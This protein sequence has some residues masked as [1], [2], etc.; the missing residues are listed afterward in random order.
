MRED[1]VCSV[2]GHVGEFVVEGVGARDDF[3]CGQCRSMVRQRDVA[4]LVID[5]F[6]RGAVLSM[7][8]AVSRGLLDEVQIYEVG[9]QGPIHSRLKGL[10]RYVNSYFWDD[11]APGEVRNGVRCEDLTKL[12]FADESFDLIL[13][14]EVFEHVFDVEKAIAEIARVLRVGGAHIFSVPVRFPFPAETAVLATMSGDGEI[15]Y[16]AP[17]RYHVAGDQSKS[18]VVS[19]FGQDFI[20]LHASHG[21]KLT[22]PRRSAPMARASQNASFVARK[23]GVR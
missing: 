11:V 13:S 8:Q 10:P 9:M 20:D 19:E 1:F 5:E 18:L 16:K 12:T 3:R 7:E 23:F 14:L 22:V 17:P 2:C 21:L 6:G 15:D 4:Q